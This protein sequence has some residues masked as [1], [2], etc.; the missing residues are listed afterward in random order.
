MLQV[1]IDGSVSFR[2]VDPLAVIIC[3]IFRVGLGLGSSLATGSDRK[4]GDRVGMTGTEMRAR[5]SG[6]VTKLP[7]ASSGAITSF[8]HD[9]HTTFKGISEFPSK[10]QFQL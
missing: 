3:G 9:S 10:G 1:W 4:D 6:H 5:H 2:V 7:A 8:E